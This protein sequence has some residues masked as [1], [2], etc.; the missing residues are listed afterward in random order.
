MKLTREKFEEK[1]N[2]DLL[3][4]NNQIYLLPHNFVNTNHM[5]PHKFSSLTHF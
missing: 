4:I 1:Q 2:D 5:S 3:E